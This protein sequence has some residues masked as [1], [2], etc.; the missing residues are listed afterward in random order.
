[1]EE[2]N[3]LNIVEETNYIEELKDILEV[4]M[5]KELSRN[6]LYIFGI[7]VNICHERVW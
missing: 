5:A 2:K 4:F 3:E 7:Y 1:M 6:N